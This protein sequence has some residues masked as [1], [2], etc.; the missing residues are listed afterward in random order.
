MAGKPEKEGPHHGLGQTGL[1]RITI[2][3]RP[4][5]PKQALNRSDTPAN[6]RTGTAPP[7]RATA[8]LTFDPAQVPD[9]SHAPTPHP[10]PPHPTPPP[11]RPTPPT[12]PTPSPPH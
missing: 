5:G 10:T 4:G 11:P 12:H 9:R 1:A 8:T 6:Q 2:L 7:T 3:V